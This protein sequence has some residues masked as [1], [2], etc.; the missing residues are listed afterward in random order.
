MLHTH[1]NKF[2]VNCPNMNNVAHHVGVILLN[3]YKELLPRFQQSAP[4]FMVDMI[5][6]PSSMTNPIGNVDNVLQPSSSTTNP[7][8]KDIH[9]GGTRF[10][11]STRLD[12]D[13]IQNL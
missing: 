9:I 7:I 3:K 13:K 12:C 6:P 4:N 1:M 5:S 11:C 2:W 8:A 10:H